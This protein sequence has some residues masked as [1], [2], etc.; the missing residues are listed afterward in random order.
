MLAMSFTLLPLITPSCRFFATVDYFDIELFLLIFFAFFRH[1]HWCLLLIFDAID[2]ISLFD[3]CWLSV[4]HADAIGFRHYCH[5]TDAHHW[6][7]LAFVSFLAFIYCF[8]IIRLVWIS[9][10]R[11]FIDA[12]IDWFHWFSLILHYHYHW[13]SLFIFISMSFIRFSDLRLTLLL[14]KL[15]IPISFT[16]I[17]DTGWFVII[18]WPEFLIGLTLTFNIAS[19]LTT[20]SI[21]IT[22]II[23]GL[24]STVGIFNES[25]LA[26]VYRYRLNG[27]HF[28]AIATG[29]WPSW[30]DGS[31]SLSIWLHCI[32]LGF[33]LVNICL[34]FHCHHHID[35]CHHRHHFLLIYRHLF[36][37]QYQYQFQYFNNNTE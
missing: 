28:P 36:S 7:P 13:S 26:S 20:I 23:T 3:A 9:L 29:Q 2:P 18:Y 22:A 21:I 17:T 12:W 24:A 11:Y 25:S 6:L 8:F 34:L 37:F 14:S 33:Q 1:C 32:G 4:Y 5:F 27:F 19:R 16:V 35:H 15:W 31:L 30:P 10:A